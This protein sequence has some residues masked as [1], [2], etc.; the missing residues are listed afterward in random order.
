MWD[1][2]LETYYK[3]NGENETEE[4]GQKYSPAL[5]LKKYLIEHVSKILTE[6]LQFRKAYMDKLKSKSSKK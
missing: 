6:S 2:F 4:S 3:G 5:Y 1:Y